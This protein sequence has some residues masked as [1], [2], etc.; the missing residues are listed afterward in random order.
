[1]LKVCKLT[2]E[3]NEQLLFSKLTFE[4]QPGSWAWIQG[5]NGS[6]KSTL[7]K[8]LAGLL[9]PVAGEIYWENK[10]IQP[11]T[12][13]NYARQRSFL[14]HKTGV[15]LRL[16]PVEILS[17]LY[18]LSYCVTVTKNKPTSAVG[19]GRLE[20]VL[21]LLQ[22]SVFKNTPC[23]KLSPGQR[24]RVALASLWLA[25]KKLWILDEPLTGLD[26]ELQALFFRELDGHLAAGGIAVLVSHHAIPPFSP[27]VSIQLKDW[28]AGLLC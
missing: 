7:L 13:L 8:V 12:D 20:Q 17:T 28:Q 26:R 15:S 4:L 25:N 2:C 24:Q 1:M 22:M 11:S 16:T 21:D 9:P 10:P 3:R 18:Q 14:G 23:E 19:L 27:A 6:G 5:T